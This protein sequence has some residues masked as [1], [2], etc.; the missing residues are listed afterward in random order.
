VRE[1][2]AI[3]YQFSSNPIANTM[4]SRLLLFV[5]GLCALTI[6]LCFG[7]PALPDY[8]LGAIP[9]QTVW[10]SSSRAFQII[11]GPFSMTVANAAKGPVE[12]APNTTGQWIF[13]YAPDPADI[14]P[15]NVAVAAGA[16]SQTF[17]I[18][19]QPNLAPEQYVFPTDKHTQPAISTYELSISDSPTPLPEELNY[20]KQFLRNVRVVGETV[21]IQAGHQNGLFEAYSDRRD[22]KSMEIIAET[23]VIRSLLRLKQTALTIRARNLI[24]A[25]NGKLQTTP[26]EKLESAGPGSA[27]GLPGTNGLPAGDV[28]LHVQTLANDTTNDVVIDLTGGRGQPGGPGAHGAEGADVRG[29]YF[30]K[31]YCDLGECLTYTAPN[32][33]TITY[34]SYTGV[35]GQ[36]AWEEGVK[37][38]P[39]DGKPAKPSGKPGEGGAGGL[40]KCSIPLPAGFATAGGKSAAPSV[41]AEPPFDRFA[42]GAPGSPQ[43]SVHVNF[44]LEFFPLRM[45]ATDARHLAVAGANAELRKAVTEAGPDG[46]IGI[47]DPR[48]SWIDPVW[49][50]KVLNHIQTDYLASNIGNARVRLVDYAAILSEFRANPEWLSLATGAQLELGQM[51]N[52]IH[53]LLQRIDGGLDYFGNPAG[54]TPMLSFEVTK[55]IFEA[56]VDRA[57]E[58]LYLSYW[59]GEKAKSQ[60]QL[61]DSLTAA[62]DQLRKD[63]ETAQAEYGAAVEKLPALDASAAE[64]ET[65]IRTLQNKL[66]F[67]ET[68]LLQETR[69]PLW[70]T[71]VRLGLKVGAMICQMAPVYQP[72]LGAV[73]QGIRLASDFDPDHPWSVITNAQTIQA[74][75]TNSPFANSAK[76]Q[77]QTQKQI[78][79][80]KAETNSFDYVK[81]LQQSAQ[82]LT[83]GVKDI[84]AFI[85]KQKAPTPEML[86]ELEQLKSD[87]PRYKALVEDI[88]ALIEENGKFVDEAVFTM[89]RIAALSDVMTHNLLAIDA[90]NVEIA[91]AAT[92]LDERAIA[93]LDNMKRRAQDRLLKYH[94]YM[95]KAYEYRLLKPYTQPLNLDGLF[96]RFAQIAALN[97]SH[98]VSAE[99]FNTLRQVYHSLVTDLA[100]SIYDG[101]I[102]NRPQ[103]S[104]PVRFNLSDDELAA[105]NAGNVV[106][107]NPYDRGLFPVV[108]ENIRIIDLK[109]FSMTT[110]AEGGVYGSTAYVELTMAHS[111]VSHLK[112][113]G[114]V[115][116]FRHYNHQTKSP[117]VWG[118][119]FDAIDNRIDDIRPSDADNSLLRS[120]LTGDASSDMLL[121][122]RPAGWADLMLTCYESNSNGKKINVKSVR[123]ELVYDFIRRN[124]GLG[125]RTLEVAA[126]GVEFPLAGSPG[127]KGVARA[128]GVP[129]LIE[130]GMQPLF[131]LD[132]QDVN[133]RSHAR[134]QFMRIFPSAAGT[135][136]VTAPQ[137]YG[138]WR[139]HQWTDKFGNPLPNANSASIVLNMNQDIAVLAEYILPTRIA[140]TLQTP[141]LQN[142]ALTIR[143]SG[144]TGIVLQSASSVNGSWQDVPAT[145]G[146][147]QTSTPMNQGSIFFRAARK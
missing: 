23:I 141:V 22:L 71:R 29:L 26:D 56:E 19:P 133:A 43:R 108:H 66:Q 103:L 45:S 144:G 73:G 124:D 93:Y 105:L 44:F 80:K 58:T 4:K 30:S 76:A 59:I 99:Q 118:G 134:G 11:G 57:I 37:I 69:D 131:M 143:W 91:P 51:Q 17:T 98:T 138:E 72:T 33:H 112:Q 5:T 127:K 55:N 75:Y 137:T 13:R 9:N 110:E 140:P 35:A 81:A 104:V 142:G 68:K 74:A 52:E 18:T 139:F 41:P 15:F 38:W 121:Y 111:G 64:L 120:L 25:D 46:T 20:T 60:Q 129:R 10:H 65:K 92:T 7:Q 128:A 86:A 122:S 77:N 34:A 27:G 119:R 47:I 49:M 95:A 14:K 89:Q 123:L 53:V 130:S 70:V 135:I 24:F 16:N 50:R 88:E 48:F 115:L 82:G 2:H 106:I 102:S 94:Y 90:L 28:F 113:D 21:E 107:I 101:Y 67:E 100:E 85:E 1:V 136:N 116:I 84:Q 87:S 78:D 125:L 63:L 31:R 114:K 79:P 12:L 36:I 54:W 61:L 32:S 96:E 126:A 39:S 146:V 6:Q 8:E 109:V 145:D 40:L 147:S 97:S 62:R 83:A 3:V 132:K 117:I 42:G